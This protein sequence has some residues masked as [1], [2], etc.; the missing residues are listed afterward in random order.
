MAQKFDRIQL[1][2]MIDHILSQ[3][4]EL[5]K[6]EQSF[7]ELVSDQLERNGTLSERQQEIVDSIYVR[8]P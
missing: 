2:Y 7:V 3:P 8:L 4:K 6:W 5:S 1:E